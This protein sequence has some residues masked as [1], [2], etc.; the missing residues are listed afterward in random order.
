MNLV[1]NIHYEVA[2]AV[3]LIVIYI[4]LYL[5]YTNND[6]KGRRFRQLVL[7]VIIADV[8]DVLTAI[9]ISYAA[10]VPREINILA[11]TAYF[12]SVGTLLF[13]YV[14]YV[15]NFIAIRT[16]KIGMYI[17]SVLAVLFVLLYFMN[18]FTG[19]VFT[20]DSE[21]NYIHGP[22]YMAVYV[23]SLYLVLYG[24][25][26][27]IFYRRYI[28]KRQMLSVL[29]FTVS[30]I[31]GI[32]LQMIWFPDVLLSLFAAS[33]AM[34]VIMFALETPDYKRLEIA[35][36][37]LKAGQEMLQKAKED[38]DIARM[39]A[40]AANRAKS[41]FLA[42][43]SHEIRTSINGVL[44]MNA[45]I[46]KEAKEKNILE[47]ARNI[48]NAGNGLL[49]LINDILDLSKIESGQMEIVPV[50]YRL[51]DVLSSCYNMVF[52]RAKDKDLELLIENNPTIPNELYGD[53]VRVRQILVNLLTNAIKYT[54]T[55]MVVM[56]ADWESIDDENIMLVVSV[57]DTGIG[58]KK[59]NLDKLFGAFTRVD[60]E[61]NRNIEG[62]GLGLNISRQFL[63]M[64]NGT[65]SVDSV[66]GKGS[67]FVVRIPQKIV[68][69]SELGDFSTYSHVSS[70]TELGVVERFVAPKARIL[71]VDDME[72][73]LKVFSGL[74]KDTKMQIDT[75]LSGREALED[76]EMHKYDMVFL[77][78]LMP[79][80]N[81]IET[82]RELR[83]KNKVFNPNTPIIV[84]TA[85]AIQGA[86]EEYIGAGFTDYLSKPVREDELLEMIR[87]YLPSEMIQS[88]EETEPEYVEAEAVPASVPNNESET[89]AI[90][91]EDDTVLSHLE[92]RFSFLDVKMGMIYCM[93][94]E[95]FYESII[96]EFRVTNKY[97][98]IQEK[99]DDAD[100]DGYAVLVHGVKSAAMT[101]GA[102]DLSE[103][104]KGLEFAAKSED[105]EYLKNNH[106][107]FMREYGDILDRLDEV[108]A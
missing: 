21:G 63:E 40:D 30:G 86:R 68:G 36:E 67:E 52:M 6:K 53:E 5:Q 13:M 46:L 88:A 94:S 82:L 44:G 15:R 42:S 28:Q 62:T 65:I 39:E 29:Y 61:R 32:F 93:D 64:M 41:V 18:V 55:G 71:V 92:K 90:K 31:V 22:I 26:L 48:D 104:A 79:V 98:E 56:T 99:Y 25:G 8:L 3:F 100:L 101:I 105:V 80:M 1:Y 20:F 49:S 4:Y 24:A 14:N 81:G 73:N 11:N 34:V 27:V 103:M 89:I 16:L 43:M 91:N 57:K 84:L 7:L 108:Y 50:N 10:A 45:I 66:Y 54:E 23:L 33:V 70:E 107:I 97:E 58:I 9:D 60:Q 37:Q 47:Y 2:A 85:N 19:W 106:Y 59:K 83:K 51:S 78:H 38:A 75:A 76:V 87:R 95:E 69:T 12:A 102:S 72:M 74:L 35:L 96:R 77:D 17:N